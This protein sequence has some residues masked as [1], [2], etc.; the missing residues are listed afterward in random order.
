MYLPEIHLLQNLQDRLVGSVVGRTFQCYSIPRSL[1]Q[2][3]CFL[4][5]KDIALGTELHTHV[6]L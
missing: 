5:R 3:H 1:Q 2:L 4:I 6:T